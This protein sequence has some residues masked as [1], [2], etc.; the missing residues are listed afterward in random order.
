[1]VSD[2]NMA[3]VIGLSDSIEALDT[4]MQSW[5]LVRASVQTKLF[6]SLRAV[7]I[8]P[9]TISM[10]PESRALMQSVLLL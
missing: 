7:G 8:I 9:K 1:M 10:L 2:E 6:T 3:V 4:I 5:E